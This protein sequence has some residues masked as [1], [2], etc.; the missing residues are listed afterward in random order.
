MSEKH[1]TIK[2][3]RATYLKL[4]RL[5]AQK[6]EKM[7]ELLDRLVDEEIQ[8]RGVEPVVGLEPTT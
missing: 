4:K 7:I 1:Q 3:W 2:I 5:A 8:R 6:P